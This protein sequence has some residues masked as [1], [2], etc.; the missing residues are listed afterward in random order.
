MA[1]TILGVLTGGLT[2]LFQTSQQEKAAKQQ[3]K[4]AQQQ[5]QLQKQTYQNQEQEMNKVNQNEADIDKLLSANTLTSSQTSLSGPTGAAP[6][7]NQLEKTSV[8]GE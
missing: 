3:A 4:L 1:S 2:G 7:K 6:N 8:L 5:Y